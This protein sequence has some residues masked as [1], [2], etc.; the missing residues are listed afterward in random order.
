[1]S[2]STL[3]PE[4]KETASIITQFQTFHSSKQK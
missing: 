3:N 1:M 2:N 4:K